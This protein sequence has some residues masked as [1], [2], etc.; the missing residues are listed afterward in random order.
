MNVGVHG[1]PRKGFAYDH[2][3]KNLNQQPTPLNEEINIEFEKNL[4]EIGPTDL[5][6]NETYDSANLNN[7]SV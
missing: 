4:N 2:H 7:L 1:L 5:K 6:F 3:L